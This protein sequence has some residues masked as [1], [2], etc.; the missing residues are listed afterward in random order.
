MYFMQGELFPQDSL[1]VN[2]SDHDHCSP[3]FY[4]VVGGHIDIVKC[5]I[6][7]KGIREERNSYSL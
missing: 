6:G 4:A 7:A 1:D 3:L 2:A 5:I